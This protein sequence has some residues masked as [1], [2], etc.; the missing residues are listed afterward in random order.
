MADGGADHE[1]LLDACVLDIRPG[2]GWKVETCGPFNLGRSGINEIG[3][4]WSPV[5]H[6]IAVRVLGDGLGSGWDLQVFSV[7]VTLDGEWCSITSVFLERLI[8][9]KQQFFDPSLVDFIGLP[10]WWRLS[11]AIAVPVQLDGED[12][13]I[14][15]ID[16]SSG[17]MVNLT[18][19]LDHQ[20][21]EID[22][23]DTTWLPD[24]SGMVFLRGDDVL[25]MTLNN[26]LDGCSVNLSNSS[27]RRLSK[28]RGASTSD[29]DYLRFN[30]PS[31]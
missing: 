23:R 15:C 29:V 27:V 19:H 28:K 9:D 12:I 1:V 10:D 24:D 31:P 3:P 18:P 8:Q 16:R 13:D 20:E 25:E 11:N 17:A 21:G 2:G 14:W 7:A 4:T 30:W 6:E 5:G 22:D 26:P